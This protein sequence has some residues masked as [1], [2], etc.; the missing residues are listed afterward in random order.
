MRTPTKFLGPEWEWEHDGVFI[1]LFKNGGLHVGLYSVSRE[2]YGYEQFV[3]HNNADGGSLA[4]W[5]ESV[6]DT[7]YVVEMLFATGVYK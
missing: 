4:E 5:G 3:L 2:V 6:E 1:R 7:K